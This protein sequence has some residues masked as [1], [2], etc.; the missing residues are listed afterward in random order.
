[1]NIMALILMKIKDSNFDDIMTVKIFITIIFINYVP[2]S[3]DIS[4][5]QNRR[6]SKGALSYSTNDS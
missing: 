3:I 5:R 2:N 4:V 1:M 6:Q